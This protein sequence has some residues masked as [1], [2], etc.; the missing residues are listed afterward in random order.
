LT[1]DRLHG[2]QAVTGARS[3]TLSTV[4]NRPYGSIHGFLSFDAIIER[5]R[6]SPTMDTSIITAFL[7]AQT[8]MMQLA[9]AARLARMNI[10]NGS[11]VV[12]LID[13]AQQN[14]NPLANVTA[15][16]GTNLDLTV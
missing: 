4:E 11:S 13:A 12:K 8:G 3:A 5:R 15:G 1:L 9:V 2:A 7:G 14:L 16:I 6:Q 10:Q